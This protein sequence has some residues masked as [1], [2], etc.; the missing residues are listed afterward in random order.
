MDIDDLK[1]NWR[2]M[3]LRMDR[4]EAESRRLAQMLRRNKATNTQ[5]RLVNR[6]K[7]FTVICMLVPVWFLLMCESLN[8][9][10]ALSVSYVAFFFVMTATSAYLWRSFSKVEY[11]S[12]PIKDAIVESYKN[13]R[14]VKVCNWIGYITGFPLIVFL[15]MEIT[16]LGIKPMII[17]AWTGLVIGGAIGV[18]TRIK[19]YR[20]MRE[21]RR[22]LEEELRD[23][24]QE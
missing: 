22:S 13:E 16:A 1:L 20:L 12:L 10:V 8:L 19:M 3:E 6:Y 14:R 21:M 4:M 23:L 18:I 7:V 9:S 17:G 15:M 11:I 5:Q 2:K 24:V